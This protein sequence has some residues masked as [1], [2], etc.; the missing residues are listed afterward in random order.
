MTETSK[1]TNTD[2][3]LIPG[4]SGYTHVPDRYDR[5]REH[6]K[7]PAHYAQ[8]AIDTWT[9]I[10]AD[11]TPEMKRGWFLGNTWKYLDRYQQ[12]NGLADLY[13]A[14]DYLLELIEVEEELAKG[15]STSA[16]VGEE[17]TPWRERQDVQDKLARE[18]G[19]VR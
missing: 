16:K 8:K 17:W 2:T 12:K 15:G 1:E 6:I 3:A 5:L 13:K 11:Y 18:G 4:A 7:K 14:A 9:K 19:K 10:K